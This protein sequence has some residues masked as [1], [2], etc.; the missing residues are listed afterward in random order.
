MAAAAVISKKG[1]EA[2]VKEGRLKMEASV[3][4]KVVREVKKKEDRNLVATDVARVVSTLSSNDDG[5]LKNASHWADARTL[6][7]IRAKVRTDAAMSKVLGVTPTSAPK[8]AAAEATSKV[9]QSKG[10]DQDWRQAS[11]KKRE[12]SVKTDW[13]DMTLLSED[14]TIPVIKGDDVGYDAG[15]IVMATV[16]NLKDYV[17]SI[18]STN[19]LVVAVPGTLDPATLRDADSRALLEGLPR[20]VG[21]IVVLDTAGQPNTKTATLFSIGAD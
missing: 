15:G 18:R 3:V 13:K 14:W 5:W 20:E 7:S 6:Q 4:Q 9:S 21:S 17:K 10:E 19:A 2:A 11:S 1:K 12:K 8:A 16:T